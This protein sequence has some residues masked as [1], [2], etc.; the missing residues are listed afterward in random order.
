VERVVKKLLRRFLANEDGMAMA[1][2]VGMIV[3]LTVLGVALIDQVTNES[4]RA[5]RGVTSNG[6]YQ[7]A[8]AGINDYLAKLTDDSQYFDHCVAKGESTRQRADTLAL[9]SHS[10]S[11]A[12]C[13]PGGASAWTAGVRWTYPS[14]KDW[15]YSGTQTGS[16]NSTLIS[17]YAYNLMITPPSTALKTNFIDIVST[18]CK[19][20]DPNATPLQ[21]DSRFPQQAIEVYARRTTPADFQYIMTDMPTG[22]DSTCW[23]STIYGRMYSTGNIYVCGATFYGNVLAEGRLVAS[24][25]YTIVPPG[26]LY[27][28]THLDIRSILKDPINFGDLLASV[29]KVQSNAAL[30]TNLRTGSATT[31]YGLDFDDPS[32]SA[33]RFNFSSSGTVQVW[34][35]V[36]SSTPESNQPYCNDVNL[37][38]DVKLKS[39]STTITVNQ[40]TGVTG[41]QLT[42]SFPSQGKIY[43]P[44]GSGWDT[45]NYTSRTDTGSGGTFTGTCSAC[46]TTGHQHYLNE[47]V[48]LYNGGLSNYIG[49][50]IPAYNGALPSNG[51][52][53]TGQ[54]AIISWPSQIKGF[55]ATSSDGSWTSQVNGQVT[56]ASAQDIDIAGDVHYASE[57]SANGIGGADNDVLG[58]IAQGNIWL[59]QYAPNNLWW[60]AA[61][62]AV[63]GSWGDYACKNGPDRGTNSYMTFVGTST[64]GS[65]SGCINSAGG[66][67]I[68]HTYRITDDGTAPACP[69][70]AP[71]CQNFDALKFL[72]PPW[73]PPLNGISTVLFRAVPPAFLPPTVP[74]S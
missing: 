18:G 14:G 38:A 72:V 20:V 13:Q 61:T 16:T 11:A 25:S 39:T 31:G 43:L 71:G 58:L 48:S 41:S 69:T 68:D 22:S 7:A 28:S 1:T 2:A 35:C 40:S 49:T 67:N 32:A 51:A 56:I 3:V 47:I 50:T 45:F 60:R 15:W 21:C 57:V 42:G 17:G 36:N 12:L 62:M 33:W 10:T 30:N 54:D 5:A 24:G 73:F 19:V 27:D 6:V 65:N 34:K 23:A 44:Y 9:V 63:D 26:K 52:I 55:S 4:N 66:Y 74:A 46:G 64:Y 29:S 8:E 37:A 59:A 53:Y 70:T